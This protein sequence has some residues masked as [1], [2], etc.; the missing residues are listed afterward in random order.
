MK[1]SKIRAGNYKVTSGNF[2]FTLTYNAKNWIL[3]NQYGTE[4]MRESTK[5]SIANALKTYSSQDLEGLN[6]QQWC[7]R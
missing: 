4:L 3:W 2:V 7:A 1:V 5:T 6:S